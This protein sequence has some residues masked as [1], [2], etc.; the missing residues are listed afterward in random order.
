MHPFLQA[1]HLL[2][3]P[4]QLLED[5]GL[6]GTGAR[7]PRNGLGLAEED[8]RTRVDALARQTNG[9]LTYTESSNKQQIQKAGDRDSIELLREIYSVEAIHV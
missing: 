1:I 4:A 5:R 9:F 7:L 3:E 2:L 6:H 8:I